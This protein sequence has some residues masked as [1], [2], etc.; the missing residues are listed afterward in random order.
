MAEGTGDEGYSRMGACIRKYVQAEGTNARVFFTNS[1][2]WK[3]FR[4][5]EILLNWAEAAYELGLITGSDDLKAEAFEHINEIRDRAGAHPHAMVTNPADIGSEIYGFPIDENLQYIRDERARELVF[6]NHRVFDIRRWRVAD[7]MFMDG[8]YTH[9][10]LAYQVLDEINPDWKEGDDPDKKY[11]WI[12]LPE[13]E[14]E[15]RRVNFNKKDY[16]DQIPG[17]EINKNPLLVRNDGH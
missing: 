16:Y 4:Y 14:R 5:G 8:V 7:I 3:V 6:E 12:F 2:P 11:M 9:G 13:V 17:G 15:G 1:Q 10:L